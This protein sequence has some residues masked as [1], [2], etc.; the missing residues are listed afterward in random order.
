[1][2]EQVGW[3]ESWGSPRVELQLEVGEGQAD[4]RAPGRL[5]AELE[6]ASPEPR[7]LRARVGQPLQRRVRARNAGNTLWLASPGPGQVLLGGHLRAADGR[8]LEQDFL[9]A[10]L[11]GDV[12]PGAQAELHLAVPA[13]DRPGSY[14]L[15]LD[16][17]VEGLCW[18]G[19]RGSG[20]LSLPL[21]VD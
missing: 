16:L 9:R 13:P 6:L 4:S 12:A 10:A 21:D 1:V 7:P 15:E 8:L 2:A 5:A 20:T 11:P 17:L 14:V 19:T 3:F 18:F